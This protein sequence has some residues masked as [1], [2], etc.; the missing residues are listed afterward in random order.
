MKGNH[1]AVEEAAWRRELSGRSRDGEGPPAMLALV[2][3]SDLQRQP[4]AE[5]ALLARPV[6]TLP[7]LSN[8]QDQS[9]SLHDRARAYLHANC[10]HCHARDAGG[11]S[12]IQFA[13]HLADDDME[14]WNATPLHATFGIADAKLLAPG[15]PAQSLIVHRTVLRG[16]GQMPPVGTLMPDGEGVTLLAQWIASLPAQPSSPKSPNP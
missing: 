14:I 13:S 1:A 6:E 3:P 11:N 7:R 2:T 8:P 9:A 12:R 5:S 4:P 15:F 10:S 16:P